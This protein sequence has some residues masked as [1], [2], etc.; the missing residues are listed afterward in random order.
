MN[1]SYDRFIR[2]TEPEHERVVQHIFKKLYD[3]GDIYKN[4]YE[5]WYLSLIHI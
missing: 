1:V 3:K 5:G 2:T 4:N